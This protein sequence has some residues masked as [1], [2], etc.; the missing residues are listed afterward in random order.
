MPDIVLSTINARHSHTSFGLRCLRAHLGSLHSRS[1]ICEYTLSHT[2][3]DIA[4]SI[5]QHQPLIIGLGVYIWN[6]DPLRRL[7]PLLKTRLPRTHIILGGP[8]VSYTLDPCWCKLADFIIQGEGE[9]AFHE[10]CHTLLNAPEKRPAAQIIPAPPPDLSDLTPPYSEYTDADLATRLLYV[11]TSRGCAMQCEY[12]ISSNDSAVRHFP[13]HGLL[14]EFSRLIARGARIFKFCD[15]TFNTNIQR[16]AAILT[17]FLDQKQNHPDIFLHFEMIPDRFPPELMHILSRFPPQSLQIEIGLQSFNS[18]VLQRIKRPQNLD[19]AAENLRRL[20]HD[21]H[22][23]IHTDL[24][25]GLPGESAESFACGFNTLAALQPHEIQLGILKKLPGAPI[26]RHD[27][28]FQMEYEPT[29]PYNILSTRDCSTQD[30]VFI[31]QFAHYWN[32][33]VNSG[34]FLHTTPL[35]IP[36]RTKTWATF[37]T[38]VHFLH[39][40]HPSEHG[41]PLFQLIESLFD[42]LTQ[43]GHPSARAANLLIRDYRHTGAKDIPPKLAPHITLSPLPEPGHG[44][45]KALRRQALHWSH[46]PRLLVSACLLGAQTRYDGRDKRTPS[47]AALAEHAELI[48]ICPEVESGLPTPRPPMN[49]HIDP[50]GVKQLIDIH[51]HNQTD[52][53][54]TWIHRALQRLSDDPPAAAILKSKSPSCDIGRTALPSGLFADALRHTLPFIPLFDE[55]TFQNLLR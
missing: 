38:L 33:I 29:P 15:R 3:D 23:Y 37:S 16:A 12:C 9:I 47:I 53:L 13:L 43:N 26:A 36:D 54:H 21:T 11:E 25:A 31:D 4:D 32:A 18:D 44:A 5:A 40:R 51:G 24:I 52:T 7:I 10:L 2:L 49:I 22:A 46:R 42:F 1:V 30:L 34:R 19:T 27:E 35:L 48:P 50:N 39:Q 8:E 41:T 17:Y 14:A 20:R 55:H 45:R 28:T 6:A